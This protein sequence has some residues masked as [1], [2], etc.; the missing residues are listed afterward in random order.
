MGEMDTRKSVAWKK[1]SSVYRKGKWQTVI[2]IACL[3]LLVIIIGSSM[4]GPV[5]ISWQDIWALLTKVVF[6]G[7]ELQSVGQ[8]GV[9]VG[10]IRLPRILFAALVGGGLAGCGCALQ[11]IFRNHL[12][13][14]GLIGTSVGAGLGAVGVIVLGENLM[15]KIPPPWI[16]PICAF[17]TSLAVTLVVYRLSLRDGRVNMALMLLAGVAMNAIGGAL[18]AFLSYL[19]DDQQLRSILFWN[20]GSF[21]GLTWLKVLWGGPVII[22]AVIILLRQAGPLHVFLLGEGEAKMLGVRTEK[23]KARI[24][25]LSALLCAASVSFT[26]VIGFVGLVVPHIVRLV[27][28]SDQRILMPVSVL[29]GAGLLVSM[30]TLARTLMAPVELPIGILTAFA[31]GP[32]FLWLL[33]RA[34]KRI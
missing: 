17:I 8:A 25:V 27:T 16:L 7:E 34:G 1:G 11:G 4:I 2:F 18:I 3:L 6:G 24:L 31:G 12:A 26:G 22:F 23:L 13:D 14:P 5:R 19:A 32:V 33:H 10:Q 9:I 15:G 30:D 20:L 29:V 28:G 21:T